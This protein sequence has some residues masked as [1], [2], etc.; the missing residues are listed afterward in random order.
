[1]QDQTQIAQRF[2]ADLKKYASR[3][4]LVLT[5]ASASIIAYGAIVPRWHRFDSLAKFNAIVF[6]TVLV[7]NP[8]LQIL[9]EKPG[10]TGRGR[11]ADSLI[12]YVFVILAVALFARR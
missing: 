2:E 5:G 1:M 10:Q 11:F 8:L 7:T 6:L 4:A 12:A 9:A 3:I